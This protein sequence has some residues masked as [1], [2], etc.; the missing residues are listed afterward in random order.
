MDPP[1]TKK[2]GHKSDKEKKGGHKNLHSSK[3]TRALEANQQKH[4][5]TKTK[6]KA[7]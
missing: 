5:N 1:Q 4:T 2:Q 7:K 6:T 3:G